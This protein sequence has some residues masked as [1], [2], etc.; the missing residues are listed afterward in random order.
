MTFCNANFL[1]I[2]DDK[3][4]LMRITIRQ[5]HQVKPAETVVL[6]IVD[7]NCDWVQPKDMQS[8]LGMNISN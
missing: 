7:Q 1:K 8:L 6:D 5:Q 3:T 4:V 2:N